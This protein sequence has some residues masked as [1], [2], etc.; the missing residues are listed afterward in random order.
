MSQPSDEEV[1]ELES[2]AAKAIVPADAGDTSDASEPAESDSEP[3]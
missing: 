3:S 1:A 2:A